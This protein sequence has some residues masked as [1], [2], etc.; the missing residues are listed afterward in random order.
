VVIARILPI[1][2]NSRRLALVK[3]ALMHAM[4][5]I[6]AKEE[7]PRNGMDKFRGALGDS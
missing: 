3:V 2:R 4:K 1:I 5:G 6:I 7:A